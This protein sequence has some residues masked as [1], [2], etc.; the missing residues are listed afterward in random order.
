MV[1]IFDD[2]RLT[3]CQQSEN[4]DIVDIQKIR[5]F[6]QWKAHILSTNEKSKNQIFST[7]K[8]SDI[9]D[10]L[11]QRYFRQSEAWILLT[12]KES[13]IVEIRKKFGQS[14]IQ[15]FPTLKSF[16]F[17]E[18][19]QHRFRSL[20]YFRQWKTQMIFTFKKVRYFQKF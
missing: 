3:Y 19:K 1:Q 18:I 9:V 4:L 5:Y 16:D 7:I 15:T 13:N 10:V 6:R 2:I 14:K 11:E 12:I 17:V 20:S 8:M